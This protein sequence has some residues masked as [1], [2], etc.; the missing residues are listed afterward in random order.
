MSEGYLY[1][2]CCKLTIGWDNRSKHVVVK[3]HKMAKQN[4][5]DVTD[6]LNKSRPL[7]QQRIQ[8]EGLVG[9]TCGKDK[10]DSIAIWLRVACRGNWSTKSVEDNKVCFLYMNILYRCFA[11]SIL[12]S[13]YLFSIY[14]K[15]LLGVMSNIPIPGRCEMNDSVPILRSLHLKKTPS[16]PHRL[17]PRVL[18]HYGWHTCIC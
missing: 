3:K 10:L 16:F 17:S 15:P 13:V 7:A 12:T 5:L 18:C 6:D 2:N 11:F 9:S 8:R 1:C 14:V 4:M